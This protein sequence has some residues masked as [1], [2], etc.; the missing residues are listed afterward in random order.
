MGGREAHGSQVTV[1]AVTVVGE[2]T[3]THPLTALQN[4]Y[5]SKINVKPFSSEAVGMSL[6]GGNKETCRLSLL[7]NSALVYE[8]KCGG[9]GGVAGS[10]PMSTAVHIT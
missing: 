8:S 4:C 6:P 9:T 1:P 2:D 7:T 3:P 5:L 10:Q